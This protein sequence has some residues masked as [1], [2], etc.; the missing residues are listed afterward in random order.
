MVKYECRR[1]SDRDKL[2]RGLAGHN[3]FLAQRWDFV[4]VDSDLV[5]RP[6]LNK[7]APPPGA[8]PPGVVVANVAHRTP[9]PALGNPVAARSAGP[10][11]TRPKN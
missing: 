1:K 10:P 4:A 2:I 3:S 6:S 9:K 8:R 5:V 11:R 7:K